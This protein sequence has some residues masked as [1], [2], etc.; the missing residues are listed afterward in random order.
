MYKYLT[1]PPQD[2]YFTVGL[3]GVKEGNVEAVLEAIERVWSSVAEGALDQGQLAAI[4][5]QVTTNQRTKL[6]RFKITKSIR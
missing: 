5:H 6:L 3:K 2:I 1:G 4:L